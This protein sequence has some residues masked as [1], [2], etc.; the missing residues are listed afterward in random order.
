MQEILHNIGGNNINN[1]IDLNGMY[2]GQE[3]KN[4]K[5]LCNFIDQPVLKAN[6][7]KAQKNKL[8]EYFTFHKL[9]KKQTIIIDTIIKANGVSVSHGLFAHGI[10][11]LLLNMLAS[12]Y[13]ATNKN[14]MLITH[15]VLAEK[16]ALTSER[17]KLSLP[18][19][20][21][22]G[23]E[24]NIDQQIISDFFH[25]VTR[26]NKRRIENSMNGLAN[27]GL[28]KYSKVGM[29]AYRRGKTV[30]RRKMNTLEL[31][32]LFE[33]TEKVKLE[34]NITNQYVA[35]IHGLTKKY[36]SR[37]IEELSSIL[38]LDNIVYCFKS[39]EIKL[40]K[41]ITCDERLVSSLLLKEVKDIKSNIMD[42]TCEAAS[43]RFNKI[44]S[45][46]IDKLDMEYGSIH[47]MDMDKYSVRAS[48]EF[49]KNTTLL[50]KEV[51]MNN[52]S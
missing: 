31:N 52:S 35:A 10:Q 41:D 49:L 7:R 42:K 5:E 14:V 43:D 38:R 44:N 13:V 22:I 39:Y 48:D 50:I 6:S 15:N 26:Q 24:Y 34:M 2:P 33:A 25:E 37:I 21:A 4:W 29:I 51:L 30:N 47:P 40:S 36:N 27:D 9:D 45:V 20:N 28:I 18:N 46:A 16:L 3:F 12:H 11:T 17:F 1:Y 32:A 19:K 8:S 23:E